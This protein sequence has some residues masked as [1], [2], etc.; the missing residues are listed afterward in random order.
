MDIIVASSRGK[1]L[2]SLLNKLHPSPHKLHVIPTS[3]ATLETI[4]TKAKSFIDRAQPSSERIH[5][6][7]IGG[8]CDLTSRV[9]TDMFFKGRMRNYEEVLFWEDSESAATRLQCLIHM[10]HADIITHKNGVA[11]PIFCTIPPAHLETWNKTRLSQHKTCTLKHTDKYPDMQRK[12]ISS[13]IEINKSIIR[14]NDHH[15]L[16]TP[17]LADTVMKKRGRT[18]GYKMFEE[19]LGDGVHATDATRERWAEKIMDAIT[20]NR[21]AGIPTEPRLQVTVSETSEPENR[22]ADRP[23]TTGL[24]VTVP[25]SRDPGTEPEHPSTSG[26][27]ATTPVELE[28]ESEPEKPPKRLRFS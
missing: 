4:A 12:L 24:L 8:Y 23:A 9:V 7:I 16:F 15:T 22:E 21:A 18:K 19:A 11:I 2:Q 13:I 27:L 3:S 10:T 28:S 1:G 17:K 20:R 5:V 26:L 14:L 6:Y 25:V